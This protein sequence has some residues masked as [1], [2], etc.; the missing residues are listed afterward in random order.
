MALQ[1]DL[2]E[3]KFKQY[4]EDYK[5]S[6]VSS[7]FYYDSNDDEEIDSIDAEMESLNYNIVFKP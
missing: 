6:L 7:R 3:G 1:G 5:D 2:W 4:K